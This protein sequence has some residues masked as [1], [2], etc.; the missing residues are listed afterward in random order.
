MTT[1]QLRPIESHRCFGGNQHVYEHDARTLGV[2][3]RFSVYV[4][5][6]DPSERMPVVIYLSGLTCSEQNVTTKSGF[7]RTASDLGVI[8]VC[9]DTSPRGEG[10]ADDESYDL[11]QGAGF[12][13]N[14]TQD[15][16]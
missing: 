1:A 4:P 3:M 5:L 7:H 15:P 14:A 10:V 2:P 9:P 6:R 13:V 8:V 11:G 16:W 12:Y